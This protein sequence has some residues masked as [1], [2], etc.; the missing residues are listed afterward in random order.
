MKLKTIFTLM[1]LFICFSSLPC[2][3][4]QE[5]I[6]DFYL[7]TIPKSGTHL[8]KKLLL[9]L[10]D[11]KTV[12]IHQPNVGPTV[13]LGENNETDDIDVKTISNAIEDLKKK[14][15]YAN[16]HFNYGPY[17]EEFSKKH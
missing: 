17:F 14:G 3:G 7:I 8:I 4:N 2:E 6:K 12:A 13:F 10:T 1:L 16:A 11:R 15:L 9:M 5:Q